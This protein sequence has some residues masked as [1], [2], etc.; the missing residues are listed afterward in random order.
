MENISVVKNKSQLADPEKL[1]ALIYKQMIAIGSGRDYDHIRNGVDNALK[2][3][4]NSVF[5]LYHID[6]E[7]GGFAFGNI[8]SGLETG[9]DY[10]WINEL[11]VEDKYRRQNIASQILSYIEKWSK[12][13]KIKYIACITGKNNTQA[14]ALYAKNGYDLSSKVWADKDLK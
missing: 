3:S 1:Y 4:S 8:C 9:A 7:L 13:R 14:Q 12:Q 10:L 2:I 5:F 6:N 11:L